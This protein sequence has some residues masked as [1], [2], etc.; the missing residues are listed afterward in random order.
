MALELFLLAAGQMLGTASQNKRDKKAYQ[1][2]QK[3]NEKRQDD[4]YV[5][6][7]NNAQKGGFNPLTALRSG[8][9]MGYSNLAG[10]ITQPLMTRSPLAA[11]ISAAT[12]YY[13][14]SSLQNK[15]LKH[16]SQMQM[17]SF[18]HDERMT[19]LNAS[20]TRI[21][22]LEEM[23]LTMSP[24]GKLPPPIEWWNY[25]KN[26]DGSL[27]TDVA[28]YAIKRK[29]RESVPATMDLRYPVLS[30]DG[31]TQAQ[32]PTL[33]PDVYEVGPGELIASGSVHGAAASAHGMRNLWDYHVGTPVLSRSTYTNFPPAP[34]GIVSDLWKK[35]KEI[36]T[37]RARVN[38]NKFSG[39]ASR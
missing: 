3:E 10:R 26:A 12:G 33:Q 36:V 16:S 13:T 27:K 29:P 35:G 22:K 20:L 9:G 37:P 28:G 24:D 19:R 5:D 14:Q 8:G 17:Q 30:R 7:R 38:V 34:I 23:A 39:T 2:A 6:L 25:E 1:A 4:Y 21:S 32:H 18:A 15:R 31:I 11:G